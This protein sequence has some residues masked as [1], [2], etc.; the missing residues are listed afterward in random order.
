MTRVGEDTAWSLLLRLCGLAPA[1]GRALRAELGVAVLSVDPEG[2]WHCEPAPDAAARALLELYLPLCARGGRAC[3]IAQLGQSLD[4]RIATATG[5]AHYVTGEADRVHLHR[6][7][8]LVDAVVVGPGTVAADDPRLTVR[9]VPGAS[10]VRVILDPRGQLPARAG[11]FTDGAA[12]TLLI[13]PG[14]AAVPA[15]VGHLRLDE[16]SPARVLAALAERGLHRVLV[17]GGG[18]TVSAFL[19]AGVLDRLH[20]TVAPVLI[21]SGR[22]AVTLPEIRTMA[23]ALRPPVRRFRLGEDV[24]FDLDLAPPGA[25]S[26]PP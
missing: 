17:E 16:Q 2:H 4:G 11:V 20:I 21:G 26:G 22:A 6:L 5:H 23:E 10:P 12:P 1:P 15:G 25:G 18:R 14:D 3:V 19:A 9:S 24:L 7:R 13:A 8:A